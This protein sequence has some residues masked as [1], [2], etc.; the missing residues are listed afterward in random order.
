MSVSPRVAVIIPCFNDGALVA[1]AVRSIAEDEPVEVVVVDD[2]STDPATAAALAGLRRDGVRV[3][4]Q[5]NGGLSS[6]RNTA[7][8]HTDAPYVFPLDS[9][10]LLVAGALARL[11]DVLDSSTAAFAYGDYVMFGDQSGYHRAPPTFDR[12]SLTYR[13]ELPVSALIR[14]SALREAG[15]WHLRHGYEDWDLWLRFAGLGYEAAYVSGGPI[16]RRRLHGSRML[17]GCRRRHGEL[18]ACLSVR[19]AELFARRAQLARESRPSMLRRLVYPLVFG[20][21]RLVPLRAE[22]FAARAAWRLSSM[23]GRV[24]NH[25][26]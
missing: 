13:N 11:A 21:R 12:W 7:V 8:A 6:A 17:S 20:R 3:V 23:R 14:R 19:H 15:G 26:G 1:A 5:L 24:E 10:D 18:Y 4:R 22:A 2:G 9:D 25:P 16:Y